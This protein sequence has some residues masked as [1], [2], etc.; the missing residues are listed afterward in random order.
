M[1]KGRPGSVQLLIVGFG[2]LSNGKTT[3]WMDA[4]H[5]GSEL[6]RDGG[7]SVLA[8]Y[9]SIAAVTAAMDMYPVSKSKASCQAAIAG[10]P[11]SHIGQ[12]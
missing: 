6:A 2:R 10:K 5:C 12:R 11:C 9:I 4:F 1:V 7:L 8:E 3:D